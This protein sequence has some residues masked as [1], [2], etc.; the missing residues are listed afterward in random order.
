MFTEAYLEPRRTSSMEL[1]L[2]WLSRILKTYLIQSNF[3]SKFEITQ[4]N[5]V[6]T[7][8]EL[9]FF[10]LAS[11]KVLKLLESVFFFFFFFH[12]F[13]HYGQNIVARTMVSYLIAEVERK[14]KTLYLK[15]KM[16]CIRKKREAKFF[17]LR[18]KTS[19]K[20]LFHHLCFF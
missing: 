17:R 5:N 2:L 9:R 13:R 4:W 6:I 1:F 8:N 19:E 3:F 15:Y 7:K 11:L 20:R 18:R 12:Y 16:S 10:K 14:E